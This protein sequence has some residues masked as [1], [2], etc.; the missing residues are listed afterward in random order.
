MYVSNPS[1]MDI[2][3]VIN[4]PTIWILRSKKDQKGF[5]WDDVTTD[6]SKIKQSTY[7]KKHLNYE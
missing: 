4:A 1:E 5:P 6:A 2:E 7:K 3:V